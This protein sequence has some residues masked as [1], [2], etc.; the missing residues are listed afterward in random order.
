M[1]WKLI[2]SPGHPR[3]RRPSA[4][5]ELD[6]DDEGSR[7]PIN[8]GAE[9]PQV[10]VLHHG[11][12]LE[13]VAEDAA[14]LLANEEPEAHRLDGVA[15]LDA[16]ELQRSKPCGPECWA[17]QLV[18]RPGLDRGCRRSLKVRA[19]PKSLNGGLTTILSFDMS[20]EQGTFHS[21]RKD[22]DWAQ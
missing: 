12:R 6:P 18:A 2:G 13:V 20:L 7:A 16:L 4:V 22:P 10:L 11:T 21:M 15:I 1:P 19:C 8:F 3:A 9:I 5:D 14:G 17:A